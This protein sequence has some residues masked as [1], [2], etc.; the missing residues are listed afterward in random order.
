MLFTER[1]DLILQAIGHGG[2]LLITSRLDHPTEGLVVLAKDSAF[3]TMYM[4][5]LKSS[6]GSGE[7]CVKKHYRAL[8]LQPPPKGLFF[9]SLPMSSL[10]FSTELKLLGQTSKGGLSQT[11][12]LLNQA[13]SLGDF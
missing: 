11:L 10:T 13:K 8:S 5:L 12:S 1:L 7:T 2:P 4:Q 3:A 9:G 6:T